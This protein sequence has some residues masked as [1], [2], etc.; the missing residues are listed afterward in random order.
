[1]GFDGLFLGRIDY[2]DKM[3]RQA[4][5]TME[6]VWEASVDLG[7]TSDLFTGILPNGYSPPSG[8]CFD[9]LC[10]DSPIMVRQHRRI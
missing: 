5:R 7:D 8:F 4:S 1:M 6:M 9:S 10:Q 2:Q 3:K